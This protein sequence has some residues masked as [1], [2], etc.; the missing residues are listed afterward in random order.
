[1]EFLDGVICTTI[2]ICVSSLH[3]C[4]LK[5]RSG[6]FCVT[7][8]NAKEVRAV[9]FSTMGTGV[10]DKETSSMTHRP[11][12]EGHSSGAATGAFCALADRC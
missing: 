4:S 12:T 9:T 6:P 11:A 7:S 2:S 5:M 1:M 10:S 8:T 3:T